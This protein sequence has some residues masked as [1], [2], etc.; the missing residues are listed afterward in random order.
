A[1]EFNVSYRVPPGARVE[2]TVGKGMSLDT[3]IRRVPEVEFTYLTVGSGFRGGVSNGQLFVKLKPAHDRSRSMAEIQDALRPQLTQVSGTRASIDGTRSIF[4]GYRQPIVVNVQGPE[5][6]RLKL[7]AGQ[8]NDIMRGVTGMAEPFSSDEGDIPQLDV[9]VDRQQAW[10]AGLGIGA[11]AGTLQPLFT[12]TR[13]T[14]WQDE[15]GYSHDVR[16]VYP[17]SLR[18]SAEDVANIPVSAPATDA[19]GLPVAIPLN[20]VAEVRAGV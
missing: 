9:R 7:I 19:R 16:V 10:A 18:A 20:Q 12:G 5:P 3:I 2:Y 4:G 11:I 6:A 15:Q 14:R 17:D 13:A 1:G 8:V